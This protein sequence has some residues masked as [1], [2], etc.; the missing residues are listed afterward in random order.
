MSSDGTTS[1]YKRGAAGSNPA[2]P[3][4]SELEMIVR[5]PTGEPRLL[6]I[7]AIAGLGEASL[8]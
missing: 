3:T 7:L 6:M 8:A 4:V 2:A 5:E 1:P